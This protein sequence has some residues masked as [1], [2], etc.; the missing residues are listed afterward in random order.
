MSN[1]KIRPGSWAAGADAPRDSDGL[2]RLDRAVQTW[3]SASRAARDELAGFLSRL[4][5][6]SGNQAVAARD[7]CLVLLGA[8]NALE[9]PDLD[10]GIQN[11]VDWLRV[12]GWETT[13]SGDGVSK[14]A[15]PDALTVPHVVI[16]VKA[17]EPIDCAARR[18][19]HDLMIAGITVSPQGMGEVWIEANYDPADDVAILFLGGLNDVLLFAAD[20]AATETVARI[21]GEAPTPTPTETTNDRLAKL[22]DFL[23][24]ASAIERERDAYKRAVDGIDAVVSVE[25]VRLRVARALAVARK[26]LT[27]DAIAAGATLEALLTAAEDG[28]APLRVDERAAMTAEIAR[29]RDQLLG[30]E[31]SGHAAEAALEKINAIRNS[32]IGSQCINWSEHIYPLVAALNDAGCKGLPYPAAKQ[33]YGTLFERCERAERERDALKRA[34]DDLDKD[35]LAEKLVW[36]GS[37]TDFLGDAIDVIRAYVRHGLTLLSVESPSPSPLRDLAARDAT[38]ALLRMRLAPF[39]VYGKA[40]TPIVEGTTRI[41][42][43][44]VMLSTNNGAPWVTAGDLRDA[45]NAF[46]KTGGNLSTVVA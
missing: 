28:G 2:K 11:V 24:K 5:Y 20:T 15:D 21:S 12:R 1:G 38:I 26:D 18:L 7:G 44:A 27:A 40:L 36:R 6:P 4:Y 10:P 33:N 13:D 25:D 9:L 34:I 23:N 41:T 29:L 30:A 37:K 31:F 8:A 43:N 45:A 3:L 46:E 19:K 16:R 14:A 22:T 32:I 35:T 17:Q 42:D 39:A